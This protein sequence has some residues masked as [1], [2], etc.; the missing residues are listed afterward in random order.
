[1]ERLLFLLCMYICKQNI[2]DYE[3]EQQII[4]LSSKRGY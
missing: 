1:M 4:H 2:H 3:K